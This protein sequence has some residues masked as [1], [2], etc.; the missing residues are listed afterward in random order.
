MRKKSS[1]KTT[2]LYIQSGILKGIKLKA[3]ESSQTHPMGSREKLALFNLLLPYLQNA[4]ILDLYAGSGALGL[5]ALSRGAK[6]VE[7]VE[8]HPVAIQ[9]IRENTHIILQA[10]ANLIASG[11]LPNDYTFGHTLREEDVAQYAS[12]KTT[13]KMFDLIIAD[14]PYN[15]FRTDFLMEVVKM[16]KPSGIYAIS[17][18]A[19][20]YPEAPVIPGLR[21]LKSRQ[22]AA[23]G[24][25]IY[26][27]DC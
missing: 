6:T 19:K 8:N 27:K 1:A 16:L 20:N 12:H 4:D 17:Y 5:E 22:Y 18:P 10:I 3:P 26:I 13:N 7:M 9:V 15:D 25:A 23:A 14:P 24:I 11:R 2:N 21:L